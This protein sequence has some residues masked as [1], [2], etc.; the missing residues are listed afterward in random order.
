MSEL[1]PGSSSDDLQA[2]LAQALEESGGPLTADELQWAKSELGLRLDPSGEDAA[3]QRG[4]DG[5]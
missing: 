5:R 2:V 1:I 4:E 3:T